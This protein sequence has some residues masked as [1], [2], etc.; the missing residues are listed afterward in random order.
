MGENHDPRF[1]R[2]TLSLSQV[3]EAFQGHTG[4]KGLSGDADFHLTPE[5]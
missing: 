4:T 2:S 1:Q 3:Q 5:C